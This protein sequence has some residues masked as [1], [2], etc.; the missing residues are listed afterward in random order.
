MIPVSSQFEDTVKAAEKSPYPGFLIS[1]AKNIDEDVKFFQLDHSYLDGPDK[2]VGS[3]DVIT[4]FDKYDYVDET[5]Y[6]ANFRITKKISERPWG[7]I[8]ATAEINL[9]NTT[10]RFMPGFDPTIGDYTDLPDRPVKL[11][12]GLNGEFIKLFTG[13]AMRPKHSLVKRL[14]TITAYDA[15]TYLSTVESSLDAFVDTPMHEIIEA[16]L[17]EQGFGYD[18]FDIE[19]SLQQ[20]IGYLMPNGKIVTDIFQEMCEAEGYLLHANED[21]II[22]GWNRLHFLGDQAPV[23]HFDYDNLADMDFS[24]APII[25]AV[26]VVATPYKP[27]AWNKIYETDD[28]PDDRLV[29]PGASLDIFADFKDE[30]NVEFPAISVDAPVY[31]ADAEGSSSYSTNLSRDGDG[32]TGSADITLDSVYNFGNT[33]RM[34]FSNDGDSPIYITNITLFGQPAKI[35]A[36]KSDIQRHDVSIQKYGIN[37]DNSKQVYEIDNTLIQDT[38]TANAMAWLLVNIYGDPHGRF[39]LTNFV[40][41]QLQ[42]GDP[43]EAYIADLDTT[44]YCVVMGFELFL[45][46]NANFTHKLYVEEREE[47]TY[48]RLDHS[49][50]D[51]PDGLAL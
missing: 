10:K 17:I 19:P 40:V 15:M 11:S 22:Q 4:F 39:D 7:V 50:L 5:A 9:N 47:H 25:N 49:Y 46:V 29:P 43:I 51:G 36:V 31:V 16:L 20:P 14:S 12:V 37:P 21:G 24:T 3:G 44:K 42:I 2:L 1:W 33:Y 48:F 8:M 26:E 41:P 38:A 30:N 34:T 23:W 32:P 35:T 18:Q 27:V 6:V 45:G 28:N 13:Y